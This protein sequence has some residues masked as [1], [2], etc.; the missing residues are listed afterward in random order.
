MMQILLIGIGAGIAAGLLFA[1]IASHTVLSFVLFYLAPLPVL[2]VA[3]GWSHWAGLV[4]AFVAA[5]GVGLVISNY[6]FLIFLLGVGLPAWWLSYLALLA[7]PV[8]TP[9]GSALTWYPVGRLV[10]WTAMLSGVGACTAILSIGVL[11]PPVP[12]I[13]IDP[14]LR[15]RPMIP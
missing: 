8:S 4:A 1:S 13:V 7:R 9:E 2:I 10:V 12:E 6:L 14:K 11:S 3:L 5:S 15:I